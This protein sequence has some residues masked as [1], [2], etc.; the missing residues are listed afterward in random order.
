MSPRCFATS[1]PGAATIALLA[2]ARRRGP[3][4]GAVSVL[5]VD[6]ASGSGKTTFAA[7]LTAA[8]ADL[9]GDEPAVVHLDDLYPGWDGLAA[10][11]EALRSQV[12]GP[13]AAGRAAAYR[14]WDWA[15]DAPGAWVPV[16]PAPWLVVEG[17]GAG[18][19]ACAPFLS[20]LAVVEAPETVR[21]ERAL[22]RDGAAYEPH[23]QRWAEQERAVHGAERPTRRADVRLDSAP[24]AGDNGAM[25]GEPPA[26]LDRSA[27]LRDAVVEMT[28]A[29]GEDVTARRDGE[30]VLLSRVTPFL[31]VVPA[32]DGGIELQ[33]HAAGPGGEPH[34]VRVG[35]D[36]LDADLIALEPLIEAA[37]AQNG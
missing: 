8:L 18:A 35:P 17:V 20:A 16:S 26:V 2:A 24:R 11:V 13:L 31:R 21:R 7:R 29:Q 3:L 14:S 12:L 36:A 28:H 32:A 25:S 33:L 4:A 30:H 34:R 22:A 5:A 27:I 23:W 37:Y 6:G 19:R 1:D 9:T 10:G 15:A